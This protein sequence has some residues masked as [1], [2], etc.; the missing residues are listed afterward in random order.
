MARKRD[1]GMT[2]RDCIHDDFCSKKHWHVEFN[3]YAC[4]LND[5][6]NRCDDFKDKS[7][8][9][10]LSCLPHQIVYVDA[11]ILNTYCLR[12]W[13]RKLKIISCYVTNIRYDGTA[14]AKLYIKPMWNSDLAPRYHIFVNEN[15]IGKTVFLSEKEAETRL[16]E[17]NN[18][19]D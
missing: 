4:D 1:R 15:A 5:I 14:K 17:L 8:I 12:E 6:E 2:C 13:A 3:K 7:R 10:E 9:I 16:K 19:Y 18:K 11:R